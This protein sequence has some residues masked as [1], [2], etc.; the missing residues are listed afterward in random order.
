MK[1]RVGIVFGGRSREREISFAG[2]RTVYDNLNKSIFETVPLFV[3]SFGN[4]ILLSWEYIYKGSIRDFYPPSHVLPASPN[5]YQVYA[6]SLGDLS[7]SEQE[8][9]FINTGKRIPLEDIRQH[10]DFAFLCLHG[11]FGEDG[12]VQGLLEYLGIP[13]SGSGIYSSSV[14]INKAIQKKLMHESGFAT[15]AFLSLQRTEWLN[16]KNKNSIRERISKEIGFP[17]VVKSAHQGSS[18]GI[19][20]LQDDDKVNF[21]EALNHA[22]FIR[23]LTKKEWNNLSDED[24]VEWVRLT[25][26]IREGIACPLIMHHNEGSTLLSHPEAILD[27]INASFREGAELL[28]L[29][30]CSA[31]TEVVVEGFIEGKEF[32]CIVIR[33][34]DGKPVALPPTE[35]RKGKELF[36]YRSKYLPGLSRKIT[37]IHL[38]EDQIQ[39]IRKDCERLFLALQFNVYAR[40]D[41]FITASGEVFLNDPNTTS[42]MMPSSFFF[43][44]AA[45]IG[46]NPSQFLSFIVRTSLYERMNEMEMSSEISTLLNKVDDGLLCLRK[47]LSSKIRVAVIM[48]GYSSE[49]HISVESGRNVYEKLSSSSK[50]EPIP[51]FLTGDADN[52]KLY[53]IPVNLMLKDNADDISEKVKHFSVHNVIKQIMQECE[54]ITKKYTLPDNVLQPRELSFHELAEA[55][56]V[57]FIALHGRPGEDGALQKNLEAVGLPYNGSGIETSKL[58]INKYETNEQLL[59]N[60]FLVARHSLV[61]INEWKKDTSS[62][63]KGILKNYSLPLIAKPVDDGCSSAVKKISNEDELIAFAG[64]IFRNDEDLMPKEAGLLH[65]KL[66]EEFPRKQQF[67]V[68]ELIDKKDA[69]RFI[70]ITGGLLT[71]VNDNGKRVYEIFEASEALSEGDVLSLEEKF[72]AGEGQNITPARYASDPVERQRISDIVKAEF[73]RAAEVLNIEGYAR[74]DAFVRIFKDGRVEVIFIEVN[75][76]PGM[77]P[78]T[79]I[80]HQSAIAGYK[81][82]EFIDKILEYG[83]QKKRQPAST[84]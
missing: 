50:Y 21:D 83:I 25:S 63:G 59:K 54:S 24:R 22:F 58:T 38:P 67:L 70:E 41:G 66:K 7:R 61:N 49:R 17:C 11:P 8:N 81:P 75:S 23:E 78:A 42:G 79:C 64:L 36:D 12:R 51:V 40:I 34:E 18:I 4:F 20:I 30:S 5:E 62:I 29:E 15:P 43:H 55:A 35:I 37:P 77:T 2:G 1:I 65:L 72:L 14:G 45:E 44:Q 27:N 19:R 13:Y 69:A 73:K 3:D 68:E 6:E 31:E 56:D 74:I 48:G 16:E 9:L 71:R 33:R 76:L 57:V 28:T 82:Y 26:D 80:F 60:G 32:S 46:L 52:Y 53:Q 10:I 47:E 84:H 39:T